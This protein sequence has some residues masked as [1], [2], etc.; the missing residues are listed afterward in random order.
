ME[1]V[2]LAGERILQ[3]AQSAEPAPR[4]LAAH[5]MGEIGLRQFYRPLVPLLRDENHDVRREAL[6]AAPKVG[7]DRLWAG[8]LANLDQVGLRVAAMNALVQGGE[9]APRRHHP[10]AGANPRDGHAGAPRQS[11]APPI[12]GRGDRPVGH[13]LATPALHCA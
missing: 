5:I 9:A 8:V 12:I 6:L 3:L 2:L 4:Q 1:G 10:A 11:V 13:A 7:H